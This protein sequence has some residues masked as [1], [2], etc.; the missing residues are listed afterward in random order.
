MGAAWVEWQLGG[1]VVCSSP[2]VVDDRQSTVAVALLRAV[3]DDARSRGAA[4]LEALLEAAAEGEIA[5]FV[6]AGFEHAC[7]LLYLVSLARVFPMGV[8]SPARELE[9]LTAGRR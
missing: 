8:E 3:A 5:R 7:D 6:A 1:A 2:Q 4:L 9:F